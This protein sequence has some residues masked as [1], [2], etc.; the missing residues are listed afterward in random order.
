MLDSMLTSF[1]IA[2]ITVNA[3]ALPFFTVILKQISRRW[4]MAF[5]GLM[6]LESIL[7]AFYTVLTFG[8][9]FG[10][11]I[12]LFFSPCL[13]IPLSLIMLAVGWPFASRAASRSN[14]QRGL[15]LTGG[16]AIIAM[17]AAPIVGNITISGYCDGQTMQA[18]NQ[19]VAALQEYKRYQGNYPSSLETLVPG[20]L[21]QVPQQQCLRPLGRKVGFQLAQCSNN[22]MLLTTHSFNGAEALRY[23]FQAGNWSGISLLDGACNYLQ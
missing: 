16:M 20:Y 4:A 21:A 9:A 18:G 10:P 12:L 17:Q 3:L 15:Y 23:N 13:T 2:L 14:P 5:L 6:T 19:I 11:G 8:G 1:A 7:V 22:V